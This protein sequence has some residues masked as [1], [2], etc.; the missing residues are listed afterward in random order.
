MN[1]NV[2]IVAILVVLVGAGIYWYSRGISQKQES[3]TT[4]ES[5]YNTTGMMGNKE[6]GG[7]M[8]GGMMASGGN[9]IQLD[10]SNKKSILAMITL[11][12]PGFMVTHDQDNGKAGKILYA[13]SLLSKGQNTIV[14]VT[15]D[16]K[17]GQ[18]YYLMLH[19]DNGDEK[20]NAMDDKPVTGNNG[21]PVMVKITVP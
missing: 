13:S 10:E 5:G 11:E 12:K 21:S 4:N 7:E 20:F 2:I 16:M 17:K 19:Y 8:G 15:V 18:T 14:A 9:S 6:N 3:T 1:K